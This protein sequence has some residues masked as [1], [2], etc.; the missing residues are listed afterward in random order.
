M[1]THLNLFRFF[2]ESEEKEFIEKNLS[3]A[4]ALCLTNNCIFLNEYV[5]EIVRPDDYKYLFSTMNSDTKCVV[6]IEIDTAN[7]EMEG[8]KII[9]AVAM[10]T[11]SSLNMDNFFKQPEYS[12]KKNYTDILITIKDVGIIIEVKR[13]GEDCKEQLFNQALPFI[14]SKIEVKPIRCSWQNVVKLLE[15]VKNV[16]QLVSQNS[17]FISDFLELSE[18]RY[19]EWFEPKPFNEIH[20]S[21]V[22]GTPNHAKLM[23]RMRQGMA[24]VHSIAGEEY[25][26]L[27]YNDRLGISVPF[28]WASEVIPYFKCHDDKIKNYVD[29]CIWPGNTKHQ[30]SFIFNKPLDWTKITTLT[31]SGKKYSVDVTSHVKLSHFRGRYVSSLNF[32]EADLLKPL[33]TAEN[34]HQQSGRWDVLSWGKFEKLMDEHFRPEYDW[35]EECGWETNFTKTDRTFFTIS[36]GYEVCLSIPFADFKA[37]DK[38]ESDIKRVSEFI[39]S[40]VKVFKNLIP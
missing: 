32:T 25:Q 18:F 17:P 1:N 11:D 30:G 28:G 2:N 21:E 20:F 10:T 22:G 8:Y 35:R 38:T 24:E 27:P 40:I 26:L 15:K 9:Y 23:K 5:R 37:L 14:K 7:L 33:Y 19:P 36:L 4:F 31:V 16:Q 34:Y 12:D 39:A 3:R 6:D 13:S 29:F